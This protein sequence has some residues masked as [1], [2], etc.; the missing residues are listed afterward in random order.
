VA[1]HSP[2]QKPDQSDEEVS[3][4]SENTDSTETETTSTEGETDTPTEAEL[5]AV[6]QMEADMAAKA[7]NA[8]NVSK[9]K[10][11]RLG[12]AYPATTPNEQVVGGYGGINIT[13]GDLRRLAIAFK[14]DG[15]DI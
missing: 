2:T 11:A 3:S 14:N 13:V 4:T 6:D 7:D 12:V 15:V 1:R 9:S 10:I 5:D 8:T